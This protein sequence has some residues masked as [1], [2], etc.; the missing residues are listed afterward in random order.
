MQFHVNHIKSG[1]DL[2]FG[3]LILILWGEW[4]HS[5]QWGFVWF[6]KYAS[7]NHLGGFAECG[8]VGPCSVSSSHHGELSF[9]YWYWYYETWV[10]SCYVFIP[11]SH[12]IRIF[13]LCTFFSTI[14]FSFF[15]HHILGPGPKKLLRPLRE[16]LPGKLLT[17]QVHHAEKHNQNCASVFLCLRGNYSKFL[18]LTIISSQWL[19]STLNTCWPTFSSQNSLNTWGKFLSYICPYIGVYRVLIHRY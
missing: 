9:W 7:K 10:G 17:G 3:S 16:H 6:A 2:L 18:C 15:F 19:I 13:N 14:F 1:C 8:S 11:S 5:K 4:I 12:P